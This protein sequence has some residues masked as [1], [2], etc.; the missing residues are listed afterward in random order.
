MNNCNKK[1]CCCSCKYQRELYKH[2]TN[3]KYKGKISEKIGYYACLK[4]GKAILF[5]KKHGLCENYQNRTN[6]IN[7]TNTRL[8]FEE[9]CS[10]NKR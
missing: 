6:R 1:E 7:K 3:K 10:L 5:E 4:F 8:E 2:P 9:N